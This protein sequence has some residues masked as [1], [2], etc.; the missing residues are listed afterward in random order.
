[1]L[2]DKPISKE[3]KAPEGSCRSQEE[4]V[5]ALKQ[6]LLGIVATEAPMKTR[7]EW[8]VEATTRAT[9]VGGSGSGEG[10]ALSNWV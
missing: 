5:S 6:E 8:S 7:K 9:A 3:L 4:L 10:N 2:V 1:M